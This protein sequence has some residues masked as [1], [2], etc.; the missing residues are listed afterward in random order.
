M[1]KQT[2]I[3][4]TKK[5]NKKIYVLSVYTTIFLKDILNNNYLLFPVINVVF[6]ISNKNHLSYLEYILF[7][8]I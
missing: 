6:S 5:R 7:Y 4:Q 8:Y 2:Q 1:S 3:H